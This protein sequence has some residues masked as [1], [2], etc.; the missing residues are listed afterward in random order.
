[1]EQTILLKFSFSVLFCKVAPQVH[2]F[3]VSAEVMIT[4]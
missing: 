1:M 2:R 3:Q 4:I